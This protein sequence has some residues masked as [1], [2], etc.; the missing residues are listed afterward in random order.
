MSSSENTSDVPYPVH[1]RRKT[2][3]IVNEGG[4]DYS[5]AET[6]G[7]LIPVTVGAINPFNPDR[8]MVNVRE[9]FKLAR[10]DDWVLISGNQMLCMVVFAMWLERFGT[11]NILQWSTKKHI[12]VP[13]HVT[14]NAIKRNA[15][16]VES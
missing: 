9:I 12:Y 5:A 7:N 16:Y 13:L 1:D 8:I 4:H 3:W 11:A 6:F 14:A 15:R 2:V 10:A